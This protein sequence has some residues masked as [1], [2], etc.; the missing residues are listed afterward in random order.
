M[1]HAALM[2]A[3]SGKDFNGS[4]RQP[5]VRTV[6]GEIIRGLMKI[7]A[8]ESPTSSRFRA[9]GRT[10]RGVSALCNVICID[11]DFSK[12]KLLQ[13]L[14]SVC[15][16]VY[17]YSFA[18][19]PEAF[20]PRRAKERWYRYHLDATG[21][22]V[23][24]FTECAELFIGEHD[25]KRFCR[26]EGKSTMRTINDIKVTKAGSLIVIDLYARE[27]LWNMVRRIVAAMRKVGMG[28]SGLAQ[29]RNAL[30]GADIS[31]GLVD[32]G[33]L[34]LMDIKYDIEFI[35][36]FTEPMMRKC[37]EQRREALLDLFFYD[38]LIPEVDNDI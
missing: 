32:P 20:S 29:V 15:D 11:T 37:I 10:D 6:E 1:W 36:V 30:D 13:A 3:Y 14:N 21:I 19:V 9:A 17:F 12:N 22:D 34:F 4:Q 16:D 7:G 28:E 31:F 24:K 25:F 18:E 33:G 35:S 2:F 5:D 8:I 27:F 38:S 23:Q 26:S